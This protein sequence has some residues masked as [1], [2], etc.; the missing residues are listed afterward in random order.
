MTPLELLFIPGALAAVVGILVATA[1]LE[2][3]IL[4]PR[5]LILHSVRTRSR[6]VGPEDVERLVA[7]QSERLIRDFHL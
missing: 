7:M 1:W 3:S 4:S 6:R 2:A 5:S